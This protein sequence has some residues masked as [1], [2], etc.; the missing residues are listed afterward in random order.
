MM[1]GAVGLA[2]L[3]SLAAAQVGPAGAGGAAGMAAVN[4][5]Y[6]F[7]FA[8]GAVFALIAAALGAWL[9]PERPL[10]AAGRGVGPEPAGASAAE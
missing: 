4:R 8:A 1:G 7:A 2:V 9:V 3:A 10:P 6:Q 5:G